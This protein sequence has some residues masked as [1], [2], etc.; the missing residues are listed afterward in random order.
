MTTIEFV[1]S[2]LRRPRVL[3]DI[4]DGR[5]NTSS[6][7]SRWRAPRC[8]G[9]DARKVLGTPYDPNAR[10]VVAVERRRELLQDDVLDRETSIQTGSGGQSRRIGPE[11]VC[12]APRDVRS[13]ARSWTPRVD[14][15]LHPG[16]DIA[17]KEDRRSPRETAV[18]MLSKS[19]IPV[20]TLRTRTRSSGFRNASTLR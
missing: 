15:F 8:V 7:S 6:R 5:S 11:V 1:A 2:R 4:V 12:V 17:P 18:T 13:P 10:V 9:I 3:Q 16:P 20:G 14:V 19:A